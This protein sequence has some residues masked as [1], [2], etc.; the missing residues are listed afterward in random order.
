[1]KHRESPRVKLSIEKDPKVKLNAL[2]PHLRHVFSG[3]G[4]TLPVIMA[5]DLNV[6]Q[7]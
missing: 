5:S 1:M 2:Q 4:D 6:H 3:K 7:V